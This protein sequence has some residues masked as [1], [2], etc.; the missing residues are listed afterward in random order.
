MYNLRIDNINKF[1]Q[2]Q[3]H[4]KCSSTRKPLR[5]GFQF[6][7]LLDCKGI[8]AYLDDEFEYFSCWG[9]I[10]KEHAFVDIEEIVV[11][12]YAEYDGDLFEKVC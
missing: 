6:L 8:F 4:Q 11:D 9:E 7:L 3:P 2:N 10:F 5:E 12:F 1:L